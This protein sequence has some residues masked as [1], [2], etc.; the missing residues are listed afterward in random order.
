MLRSAAARR[1]AAA[2]AIMSASDTAMRIAVM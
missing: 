1:L 2:A